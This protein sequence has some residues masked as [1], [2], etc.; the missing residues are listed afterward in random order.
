MKYLCDFHTHTSHCDGKNSPR[1]MAQRALALG[2]SAYGFSG[3]G[4]AGTTPTSQ[5]S[6]EAE[7]KY[8]SEVLSLRDEMRGRMDILLGVE[9]EL[10]GKKYRTRSSDPSS[11]FDYVIGGVHVI[12]VGGEFAPID[13]SPDNVTDAT[14]RYFGGDF[15][16]LAEAYFNKVKRIPEEVDATFIAHIDLVSKYRDILP[17]TFGKRYYEAAFD[18]VRALIPYHIPFE[19][20][21]GAISRGYRSTPYPDEQILR[22]IRALGGEVMVNGD[23]HSAEM[24]G[25][26]LDLGEELALRCGFTH[27]VIITPT[28]LDKVEM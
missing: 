16:S 9:E 20:N 7:A 6:A 17:L 26:Y 15:E 3:H 27:K 19:I 11:P 5:M 13:L 1:E 4:G 28:G 14:E 2:F 10:D 24:L 8:I 22:Y 18:A 21:V 23:C 25:R 12:D